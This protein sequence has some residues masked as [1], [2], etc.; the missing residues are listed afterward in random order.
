MPEVIDVRT[1]SE[2]RIRV[3]RTGDFRPD[4]EGPNLADLT[5]EIGGRG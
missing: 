4:S 2:G 1:E 5:I 3:D